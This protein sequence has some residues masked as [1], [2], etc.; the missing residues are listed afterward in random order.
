LLSGHV[1]SNDEPGVILAPPF[2]TL[3][4]EDWMSS[5]APD[6]TRAETGTQGISELLEQV[7]V[8]A[9]KVERL[10]HGA[11]KESLRASLSE[12]Q[13]IAD[14]LKSDDESTA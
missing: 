3:T 1:A 6:P 4:P 9:A 14:G 7:Q 2:T 12:L 11:A 10:P 13:A 8:L 5:N